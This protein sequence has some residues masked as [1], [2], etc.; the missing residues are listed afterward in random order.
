MLRARAVVN[1]LPTGSITRPETPFQTPAADAYRVQP[2]LGAAVGDVEEADHEQD[3]GDLQRE[4][5]HEDRRVTCML[6]MSMYVLKTANA[7]RNHASAFVN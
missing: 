7:N 1:G 2:P 4:E 6:A 3:L 5:D